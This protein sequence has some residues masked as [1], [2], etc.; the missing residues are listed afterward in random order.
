M[1]EQPPRRYITRSRVQTG[2]ST[3]SSVG[4]IRNTR[5]TITSGK[6]KALI[7]STVTQ[8]NSRSKA[9]D[10]KPAQ[11]SSRPTRIPTK[12]AVASAAAT[13]KPPTR[14][15]GSVSNATLTAAPRRSG[16]TGNK[17]FS[18]YRR[19]EGQID[20][21]TIIARTLAH[22]KAT[23]PADPKPPTADKENAL[24]SE[25]KPADDGNE[26][27]DQL[28]S[29][30]ISALS[31]KPKRIPKTKLQQPSTGV[32][33]GADPA[34]SHLSPQKA[35]RPKRLHPIE[36][37][38][39]MR[40]DL[41]C[42]IS[43]RLAEKPRRPLPSIG[44]KS[45]IDGADLL[46]KPKDSAPTSALFGTP[47]KRFPT[48]AK[49]KV[50]TPSFGTQ[51]SPS[52]P[53]AL[54]SSPARRPVGKS[55]LGMLSSK[56]MMKGS[57]LKFSMNASEVPCSD[58]I[59]VTPDMRDDVFGPKPIPEKEMTARKDTMQ[60]PKKVETLKSISP[61]KAFYDMLSNMKKKRAE[62]ESNTPKS[63]KSDVK[64]NS[65]TPPTSPPSKVDDAEGKIDQDGDISMDDDEGPCET[66][67]TP[68]AQEPATVTKHR[69]PSEGGSSFGIFGLADDD[70]DDE[71]DCDSENVP[72]PPPQATINPRKLRAENWN[73]DVPV[74][75]MLLSKDIS[76]VVDGYS[77]VS[78]PKMTVPVKFHSDDDDGFGGLTA[79]NPLHVVTL[80][81]EAQY[82]VRCAQEQPSTVFAGAVVYID[83]YTNDGHECSGKFEELLKGMGAKVLQ[84]WNWNPDSATPGKVGITHVVF[85]DGSPRTLQKV[86]AAKGLV[87]CVRLNWVT[88]CAKQNRWLDESAYPVDLDDIPRGGKV[89][90][91]SVIPVVV[92]IIRQLIIFIAS[93][94]NGAAEDG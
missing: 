87:S 47:A 66:S 15:R 41:L 14:S 77:E 83:A 12:A 10:D 27:T 32:F 92:S 89:C 62:A 53:S 19:V 7:E 37:E 54:S 38:E 31:V 3:A 18:P 85:K 44:K 21:K 46:L 51:A 72:P 24:P 22:K 42:P 67:P 79:I 81:E 52:K 5:S 25:S 55:K 82:R 17:R 86:K 60:G 64:N 88:D 56:P 68:A 74:D 23:S 69:S 71:M 6:R 93:Q 70:D 61:P 29:S 2:E 90:I 84:Q 73:N 75:P 13:K 49:V 20:A 45:A 26:E 78:A 4:P 36:D 9:G 39:D 80:A 16:R 58:T 43:P 57:S 28:M 91:P 8:D 59:H 94:V 1:A 48:P 40:D 33:A 11:P 50:S 65:T 34:L 30:S 76:D 35:R 63:S